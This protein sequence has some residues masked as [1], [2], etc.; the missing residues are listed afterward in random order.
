MFD[1]YAD[2]FSQR[3]RSYHDAMMRVP[4]ARE[5]EFRA[6]LDPVEDSSGIVCDM[7]S[8]GGYLANYLAAGMRYV[9]VEPVKEFVDSHPLELGRALNVPITDVP[10]PDGS[11]DYVISLAGLHHEESLSDVFREMRRLVRESGR[12]IIADIAVNTPP[13]GFLNG[14]VARNNPLGHD[15]RFLDSSTTG[16]LEAAGLVVIDDALLH[17]PWEFDSPEQAGEFCRDLFGIVGLSPSVIIEAL[18]SEI[19][20]DGPG[21]CLRWSLRRLICKR[22]CQ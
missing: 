20:F 9:G 2:I 18:K 22:H 11:V 21:V 4:R 15:G 13:A 10:L 14:F 1:S 16:L 7:P 19:G 6:V 3:S 5:A 12:V 8:G 17:L